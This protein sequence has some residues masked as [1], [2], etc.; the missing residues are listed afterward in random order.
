MAWNSCILSWIKSWIKLLITIFLFC[1]LFFPIMC[2]KHHFHLTWH[3]LPSAKICFTTDLNMSV[4]SLTAWA[5]L[6]FNLY[7]SFYSFKCIATLKKMFSCWRKMIYK[8]TIQ[9]ISV[10]KF[11]CNCIAESGKI[12]ILVFILILLCIPFQLCA[13]HSHNYPSF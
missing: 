3:H 2:G 10:N 11:F 12:S 7:N 4:A 5:T 1:S 8:S 13:G 9:F 6:C